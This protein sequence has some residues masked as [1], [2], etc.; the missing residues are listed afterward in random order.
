MPA[1]DVL[2]AVEAFAARIHALDPKAAVLGE[3]TLSYQGRQTQVPVT[4]PVK[5]AL[6][7]A[8]RS[9]HDPRDFGSCDYC[10]DGRLDDNF[11]CLSCGRP[12][13]LFGQMLTERAEGHLEPPS[14]PAT[15]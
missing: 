5:A 6:A 1:D 12:N 2:A 4:A 8:L 9:Y 13:G 3:L 7:E 10:A 15:D 11:L 14:L